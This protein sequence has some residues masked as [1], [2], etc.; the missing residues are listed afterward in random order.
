MFP[1]KNFSVNVIAA[2]SFD[3]AV[4]LSLSDDIDHKP[5]KLGIFSDFFE[6]GKLNREFCATS[7]KNCKKQ[8][9]FCSSFK[10]LCALLTLSECGVDLFAGV[11]ME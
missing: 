2:D 1:V 7:A 9:I 3:S 6:H 11:Y 10:Y 5:G 8:N 4:L